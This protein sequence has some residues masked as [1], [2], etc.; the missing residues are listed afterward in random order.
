MSDGDSQIVILYYVA[1]P[2]ENLDNWMW[3][4]RMLEEAIHGVGDLNIPFIFDREKGLLDAMRDVFPNKVHGHYAHHLKA[5]VRFG[6]GKS[7]EEL[8][9]F[10]STHTISESKIPM[11]AQVLC[12]FLI[13]YILNFYSHCLW[14]SWIC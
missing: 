10:V 5:N 8:F 12:V 1:A 4:L 3:F 7:F 11:A 2:V 9:W 6:Y 14:H 13:L